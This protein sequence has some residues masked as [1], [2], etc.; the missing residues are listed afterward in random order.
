MS[1][2]GPIKLAVIDCYSL[3]DNAETK[4]LGGCSTGAGFAAVLENLDAR[5]QC[6][7]FHPQETRAGFSI[8]FSQFDGSVW[9]GSV[10]SA[11]DDD[12]RVHHLIDLAQAGF[13]SGKPAFGACFGLQ[14][15]VTTLGG[16]VRTNPKGRE[17][18]IGRAMTLTPAGK[19]HALYLDKPPQFD[20]LSVH[21]DEVEELPPGATILAGNDTSQV[22]AAVIS[23]GEKLF[24]G[25]QY[26][27]EFSLGDI[28]LI[29]KRCEELCVNE[30]LFGDIAEL[31]AYSKDLMALHT[32]PG[33]SEAAQR[34]QADQTILDPFQRTRELANWLTFAVV[35]RM[36]ASS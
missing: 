20:A 2:N 3:Q 32:N 23:D 1:K 35:P 33:Q 7:L 13:D 14:L 18:G 29:L 27:P 36:K 9:S 16:K 30:G 8:D 19:S 24:W 10:S 28:S 5:I 6:T 25:V 12:P 26:H 17:I 31:Q 21:K 11:F 22:Q 15:M 4:A 34:L